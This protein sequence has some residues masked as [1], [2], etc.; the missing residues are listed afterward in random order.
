MELRREVVAP[1]AVV[2]ADHAVPGKQQSSPAAPSAELEQA[3]VMPQVAYRLAQ[4]VAQ[5][6]DGDVPEDANTPQVVAADGLV[7]IK[8]RV[9][10]LGLFGAVPQLQAF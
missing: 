9:A 1:Q 2:A 6:S 4:H 3:T 10:V 8:R 5:K 7:D